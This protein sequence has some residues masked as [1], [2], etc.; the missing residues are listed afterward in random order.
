MKNKDKLEKQIEEL[1][2]RVE[3]LEKRPICFPYCPCPP[4]QPQQPQYPYYWQIPGTITSP[5]VYC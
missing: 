2:K 1:K 4:Q 3:E 5:T